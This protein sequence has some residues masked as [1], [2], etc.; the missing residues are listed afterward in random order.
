MSLFFNFFKCGFY[1]FLLTRKSKS[2]II[3]VAD[4]MKIKTCKYGIIAMLEKGVVFHQ[5]I[6]VVFVFCLVAWVLLWAAISKF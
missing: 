5:C 4:K 1:V 3:Y 2:I 6:K